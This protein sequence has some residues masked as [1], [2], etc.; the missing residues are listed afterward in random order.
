[1]I[2]SRVGGEHSDCPA[3]RYLGHPKTRM[4]H[5]G[6]R[7]RLS[8]PSTLLT[9]SKHSMCKLCFIHYGDEALSARS[10]NNVFA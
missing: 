5:N 9:H 8:G 1:M 3:T 10:C 7:G 6:S 2:L 4:T